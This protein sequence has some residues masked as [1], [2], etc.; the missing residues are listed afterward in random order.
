MAGHMD[1]RAKEIER[2]SEGNGIAHNKVFTT[3]SL[4]VLL[5]EQVF[6]LK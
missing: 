3:Q 1:K 6:Y 2:M 5:V 4:A